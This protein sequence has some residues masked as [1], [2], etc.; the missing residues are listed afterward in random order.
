ML[1]PLPMKSCRLNGWAPDPGLALFVRGAFEAARSLPITPAGRKQCGRAQ[2]VSGAFQSFLV[3][4]LHVSMLIFL[5]GRT[6]FGF[7]VSE[8]SCWEVLNVG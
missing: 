5:C 1:R 8:Q 2:S 3:F 7:P 6:G 4:L